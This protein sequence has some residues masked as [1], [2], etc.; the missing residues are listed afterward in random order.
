[1]DEQ[2]LRSEVARLRPGSTLTLTSRLKKR[3]CVGED[4]PVINDVTV[5]DALP[6]HRLILV[7]ATFRTSRKYSRVGVNE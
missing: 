3:R 5:S 1:M 6:L 7:L 4:A 2:Q